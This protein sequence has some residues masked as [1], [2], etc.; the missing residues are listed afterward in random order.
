MKLLDSS[1][2]GDA[3]RLRNVLWNVVRLSARGKAPDFE[4]VFA[5]LRTLRWNLRYAFV[6]HLGA[7]EGALGP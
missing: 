6:R 2:A 3:S 7:S 5:G 1:P 4:F